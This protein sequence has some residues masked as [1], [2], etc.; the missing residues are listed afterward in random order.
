[1]ETTIGFIG[2]GQMAIALASGI[3]KKETV[4]SKNVYGYDVCAEA[5]QRFASE[6]GATILKSTKDLV[7][8][9]D[10]IFL[11]VKPQQ[12]G[13]VLQ[14]LGQ[15]HARDHNNPLWITIAAGIPIKTY[16]KVLGTSARLVRVMPNTPCLVGEGVSGFCISEGATKSD[17]DLAQ[18]L[19]STVGIAIQFP[20]RQLDAVT[21]LSG[22]GPAYIYMMIEAMADG[23]VKMGLSRT[24]SLKLAIQTIYGSAKVALQTG[25]H[26]GI[27]KDK[28]CSPRGTTISAVHFLEQNGFRSTLIGA[29]EAATLRSKE[30]ASE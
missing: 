30:L 24:L 21:G 28:V 11:S 6:T 16:L 10:V 7:I 8:A 12:M 20:E 17:V 2:T 4:T 23:G 3:I 1:M 19:L 15:I 5:S 14:E 22:S 29:V 18:S 25:E 9:A 13:D 27:L 26:P